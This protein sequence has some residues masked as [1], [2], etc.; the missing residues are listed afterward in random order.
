A[1]GLAVS[2]REVGD[3]AGLE[4][5]PH[6]RTRVE[7]GGCV[8]LERDQACGEGRVRETGG[9]TAADDCDHAR[10]CERARCRLTSRAAAEVL[11]GHQAVAGAEARGEG[12]VEVG[13]EPLGGIGRREY[14]EA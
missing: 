11:A 7:D 3:G 5:E 13:E 1:N 2:A 14:G 9:E 6:A 10:G 12:G 8:H 4:V